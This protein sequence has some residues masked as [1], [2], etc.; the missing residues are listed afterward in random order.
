MHLTLNHYLVAMLTVGLLTLG[1]CA[2][3]TLDQAN[4]GASN[5]DGDV[6]NTPNHCAD[7]VA[8]EGE[9]DIDCG[10]PCPPCGEGFRCGTD[11]ANCQ[12]GLTC[13]VVCL[14]T[15]NNNFQD[16]NETGKDCGGDVCGGCGQGE[17][18]ANDN[19][20]NNGLSCNAGTCDNGCTDGAK[21]NAESDVDCGGPL[22]ELC[23]VGEKCGT[24]ADCEIGL[25]CGPAGSCVDTCDNGA[26][27][28]SESDADCGGQECSRCDLGKSCSADDDCYSE[29]CAAG[30]CSLGN[31]AL[32]VDEVCALHLN[33][34]NNGADLCIAGKAPSALSFTDWEL[35]YYCRPGTGSYVWAEDLLAA[36]GQGR[37]DIDWNM[38]RQCLNDSRVMQGTHDALTLI[39]PNVAPGSD[40]AS[41]KNGICHDFYSGAVGVGGS[42]SDAWDCA[43]G[44]A[45]GSPSAFDPQGARCMQ[46]ATPG[47][48]CGEF[49]DCADNAYCKIDG[50]CA[51][52]GSVG[53]ACE[54]YD[55]CE[56]LICDPTT[57]L[58][59]V[60]QANGS[61]CSYPEDC[62]SGFCNQ[63]YACAAAPLPGAT[64]ATPADCAGECVTC[65]PAAA[66]GASTC[67]QPAEDGDYCR[68][69][70]DCLSG[71]TCENNSCTTFG[72]GRTCI[73]ASDCREGYSCLPK[74][75]CMEF[76]G[77]QG[78]CETN[79]GCM[80]DSES[81]YCDPSEGECQVTPDTAGV[82]CLFDWICGSEQFCDATSTTCTDKLAA[83]SACVEGDSSCGIGFTCRAGACDRICE[84]NTDCA[85][86]QY[87]NAETYTCE[88]ENLYCTA[89]SECNNGEFC[90]DA[91]GACSRYQS[92]TSSCSADGRCEVLLN[93]CEPKAVDCLSHDG[94]QA[95]CDAEAGC[96]YGVDPAYPDYCDPDASLDCSTHN[97]D[98]AACNANTACEAK[99]ACDLVP[100]TCTNPSTFQPLTQNACEN[101]AGC[102]WNSGLN[103][104]DKVSSV[105]EDTY[106][107]GDL[108]SPLLDGADCDSGDCRLNADTGNYT[109]AVQNSR[110]CDRDAETLRTVFLFGMV[111]V[112]GRSRRRK[113]RQA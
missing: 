52:L 13:A 16:V 15:C 112:F 50:V 97:G 42:C 79:A 81:G 24:D 104:C 68:D 90:S 27:D 17:G 100:W 108:C 38:A 73:S 67:Q 30:V 107:S 32:S 64:C 35:D 43:D 51:A 66:G 87:C 11:S 9:T 70:A 78:T 20:C 88:T 3:D 82:P 56:T 45:C 89:A 63:N 53:D 65:R 4:T 59:A 96:A 41:L 57:S 29:N 93:Q 91:Q 111:W 33:Y 61:D 23:L 18:C 34:D 106:T 6:L 22:C 14:D 2:S 21:T 86:G 99:D 31:G 77:D 5:P 101:K 84:Y 69:A 109:C 36:N 103:T 8:N 72:R 83:G 74:T 48:A 55:E 37:V 94:D 7:A 49:I 1:A 12:T 28:G 46:P 26:K 110:G 60:P 25:A 98:A 85:S 80:Y 58:C 54:S 62:E 19:D 44:L 105:C 113:S 102:S 92:D 75:N 71:L 39:D 10:G 95:A 47:Q 76:D 40:W